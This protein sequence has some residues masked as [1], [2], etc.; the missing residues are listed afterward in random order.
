MKNYDLTQF[1]HLTGS[2]AISNRGRR[3]VNVTDMNFVVKVKDKNILVPMSNPVQLWS[4]EGF[5]R[6]LPLVI[7]ITGWTTNPNNILNRALDTVYE[8]YRCRGNVNFVVDMNS[9]AFSYFISSEFKSF[10]HFFFYLRHF[11]FY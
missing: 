9:F 3:R 2:E 10:P 1:I 8:A 4:T 5:N 11:I 6:Y 7:M